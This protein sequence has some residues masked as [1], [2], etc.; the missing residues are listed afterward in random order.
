M[1]MG[2]NQ[3]ARPHLLLRGDSGLHSNTSPDLSSVVQL[4]GLT[5]TFGCHLVLRKKTSQKTL[6]FRKRAI[7]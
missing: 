5:A 2:L 6:L 3:G 1:E 4:S 7:A